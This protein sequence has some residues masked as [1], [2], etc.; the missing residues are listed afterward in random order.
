MRVTAS[1]P[2]MPSTRRAY[3]VPSTLELPLKLRYQRRCPFALG[4][5]EPASND[6]LDK[7]S[8]CR[9][10]Q[11]NRQR[12]NRHQL[13]TEHHG[14]EVS[15]QASAKSQLPFILTFQSFKLATEAYDT[16]RWNSGITRTV[17]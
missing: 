6:R 5:F 7:E 17:A 4:F 13:A 3:V 8:H 15:S 14:F 2:A 11:K 1:D 10:R 16:G 9:N 12:E